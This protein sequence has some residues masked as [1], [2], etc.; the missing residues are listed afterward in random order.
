MVGMQP[1]VERWT[2]VEPVVWNHGTSVTDSTP[3][4]W[5]PPGYHDDHVSVMTASSSSSSS[6]YAAS[7]RPSVAL[8]CC[9]SASDRV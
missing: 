6:S 2:A 5:L 3:A 7:S 8:H 1:M 9:R 4:R